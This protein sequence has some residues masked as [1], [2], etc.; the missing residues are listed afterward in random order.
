[1]ALSLSIRS[2]RWPSG[3]LACGLRTW[4]NWRETEGQPNPEVYLPVGVGSWHDSRGAPAAHV[5]AGALRVDG[6][7]LARALGHRGGRLARW[8]HRVNDSQ[9]LSRPEAP[10]Q[11]LWTVRLHAPVRGAEGG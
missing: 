1:R 8:A 10:A 4:R 11:A 6:V 2:S 5:V 3:C 7:L 9:Q